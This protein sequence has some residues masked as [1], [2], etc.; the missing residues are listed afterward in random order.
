MVEQR[1]EKAHILLKQMP[2]MAS[3]TSQPW[4]A[5]TLQ[6]GT[7]WKEGGCGRLCRTVS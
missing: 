5:A 2:T 6:T 1:E 3:W 7:N 4:R